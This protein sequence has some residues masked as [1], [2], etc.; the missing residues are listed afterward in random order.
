MIHLD[1]QTLGILTI[2]ALTLGGLILVAL[3]ILLMG[4]LFGGAVKLSMFLYDKVDEWREA[5]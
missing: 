2:I 4:Y 3:T 5:R 1:D